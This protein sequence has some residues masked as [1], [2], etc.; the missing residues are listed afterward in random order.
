MRYFSFEPNNDY[1]L[2]TW[3]KSQFDLCDIV[4][5]L[6]DKK[7]SYGFKIYAIFNR[8]EV[9]NLLNYFVCDFKK[10]KRDLHIL[11]NYV[12]REGDVFSK[13][14]NPRRISFKMSLSRA[15][16]ERRAYDVYHKIFQDLYGIL[17]I[18]PKLNK[19]KRN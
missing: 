5:F 1:A 18:F 2:D 10:M 4:L 13:D 6:T 14:F 7:I 16:I 3:V 8:D 15:E 11:G 12:E 9:L 19:N 17:T